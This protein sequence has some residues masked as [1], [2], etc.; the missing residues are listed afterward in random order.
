MAK[1]QSKTIYVGLAGEHL[2][3]SKLSP[4]CIVRS[5]GEDTGIDLYCEIVAPKTL[6]LFLHFFCQ[7]KTTKGDLSRARIQADFPYWADQ[8]VPVFVFHVQ[9]DDVMSINASKIW[10]HD[11]PY[12]LAKEDVKKTRKS[13][14]RDVQ[15]KFLL[16]DS[17]NNKDPMDLNTFIYNHVAFAYGMWQMRRF[18]LVLP[19]PEINKSAQRVFVGGLTGIYR[20]K[21]Q[22]AITYAQQRMSA[23]TANR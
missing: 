10:I 22:R 19:N 4:Y 15:E 7:V 9:Y 2:V 12:I 6:K 16:S 20:R 1:S 13:L 8:P 3:A 21:I 23:E 17:G 14:R 18:G 5:V 11:V